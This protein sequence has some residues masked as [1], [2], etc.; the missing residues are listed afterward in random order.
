MRGTV[1]GDAE[2][3]AAWA[4]SGAMALTGRPD[5][6]PLPP[7][8]PL[9]PG[10]REAAD[11]IAAES[12]LL[13]REV[14]LDPLTLLGERAAL[15]GLRRGGEVS[16]GG[17]TR[18]LRA[19]DGWLA[20]SLA[21]TEDIE[22]VPAWLGLPGPAADPWTAATI[23]LSTLDSLSIAER[24]RMLG[25]P[26]AALGTVPAATPVRMLD[27]GAT[28]PC[29]SMEGLTVV[30]L[31]SLWAGP[32][33]ASLLQ[34]AGARVAKVESLARPDGL[35]RGDPAFF[36]LLNAGKLSVA[37]DLGRPAG[38]AELRR[39]LA[40]ADV[41][42]ESSR[43][44]ALEQW[45][46]VASDL[47]TGPG[48]P[49][50]WLSITG[51][52][53]DEPGRDWVAF[54]DDAAVAGGLLAWD[55]AAPCFCADAVADPATALVAAAACLATLRRGGRW[56]LDVAMARVA[57]SLAGPSPTGPSPTGPSLA[58][59]TP[60]G[61]TPAVPGP[62][63]GGLAAGPPRARPSRGPARPLG[64]DTASVLSTMD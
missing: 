59:P 6:P 36:D 48:R 45:G 24:G 46:I 23:R 27:A 57:A 55:D 37:L 51:Y 21:R 25:L 19:R 33:C 7:P 38:V 56:L 60:T 8:R 29:A 62:A 17:H 54:G 2:V 15:R 22:L 52:G 42:I 63:T 53:R 3:L 43:P 58:G 39:L 4:D 11:R 12:R 14:R 34:L 31:S 35:R 5:G 44:R 41:V 30:D 47:L 20:L 50:V 18:L 28:G 13:G 10:L 1:G 61:P 32:L 16:C 26:V 40:A 9:V 64:A 49:R